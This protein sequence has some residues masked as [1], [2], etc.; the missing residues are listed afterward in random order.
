MTCVYS[1]GRC[2]I[3]GV[4]LSA[5]S[6]RFLFFIPLTPRMCVTQTSAFLYFTGQE[7]GP[8][9]PANVSRKA[10]HSLPLLPLIW[11]VTLVWLTL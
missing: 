3:K 5:C 9:M 8:Q 11:A 1:E 10:Q 7:A 2:P 6:V 4:H